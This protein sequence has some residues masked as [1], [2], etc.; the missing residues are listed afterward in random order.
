MYDIIIVGAGPAGLTAAIYALRAKKKVLLL[1]ARCY[2]GQ[3]TNA[4]LVQNYPGFESISGVDLATEMYNYTVSSELPSDTKYM[5]DFLE[6]KIDKEIDFPKF[7]KKDSE[8]IDIDNIDKLGFTVENLKDKLKKKKK[9]Y[10]NI[11]ICASNRVTAN[12]L[13]DLVGERLTLPGEG[14]EV[15]PTLGIN[16]SIL[17]GLFMAP[18]VVASS[19]KTAILASY[20][21]E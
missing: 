2:G 14:L 1:E 3:I 6:I 18:S 8:D 20:L 16:K 10:K 21:L 12:K 9:K 5:N 11:I 7:D 19:L 17:Q 4:N 13:I 15:G